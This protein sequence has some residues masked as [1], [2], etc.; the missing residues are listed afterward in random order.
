[1]PVT[2][3]LESLVTIAGTRS[4]WPEKFAALIGHLEG[5]G[6]LDPAAWSAVADWCSEQEEY[7]LATAFAWVAKRLDNVVPVSRPPKW[8]DP[9]W[10]MFNGLPVWMAAVPSLGKDQTTLAGAVADIA[11]RLRKV[12][13]DQE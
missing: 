10:W 2:V 5:D 9:Q 3:S 11:Y 4:V 7:D 1:M 13:E 12:R 6:K 8:N